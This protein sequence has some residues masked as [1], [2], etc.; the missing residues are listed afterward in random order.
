[1]ILRQSVNVAVGAGVQ[2]LNAFIVFGHVYLVLFNV[3]VELEEKVV[4]HVHL[5]GVAV[6]PENV[7]H[8]AAGSA[9][10]E[11]RPVVVPVNNFDVGFN[12]GSFC[13]LVCDFLQTLLLVGVP[14]VNGQGSSLFAVSAG[15]AAV[16][17]AVAAACR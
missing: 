12:A 4:L 17:A 10:L 16:A 9:C 3:V 6:H 11:E 13:P 15:V 1:M 8:C 7:G 14:D 2:V 5:R